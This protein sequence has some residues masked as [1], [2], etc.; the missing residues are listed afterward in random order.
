MTNDAKD[1]ERFARFCENE[2]GKKVLEKEV[3]LIRKEL[4][5]WISGISLALGFQG[6][7]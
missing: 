5:G 3:A 1:V 2:L 6:L 4:A 7:E